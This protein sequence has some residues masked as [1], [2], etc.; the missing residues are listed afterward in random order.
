MCN[1][2]CC[3]RG[4]QRASI[5]QLIICRHFNFVDCEPQKFPLK[6]V[7]PYDIEL[8]MAQT[9]KSWNDSWWALVQA[10]GDVV[11]AIMALTD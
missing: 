2:E 1:C 7:A 10:D 9:G 3:E 6:T 5:S 4:I 11:N 8:A